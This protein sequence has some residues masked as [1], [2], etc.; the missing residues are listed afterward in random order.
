MR[1]N[2]NGTVID[3]TYQ[4]IFEFDLF[5]K[6]T[7]RLFFNE[8]QV[9]QY[10]EINGQKLFADFE[11]Y[12]VSNYEDIQELKIFT[13]SELQLLMETLEEGAAYLSKVLDEIENL[14]FSFYGEI[15]KKEWETFSQF[16]DGLQWIYLAIQSCIPIVEKQDLKIMNKDKLN[17]IKEKLDHSIRDLE[18]ALI[19]QEYTTVGDLIEYE[20]RP[21]LD[22]TYQIFIQAIG[23]GE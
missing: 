6:K 13:V 11:R 15:G 22:D 17:L 1:V 23:C 21:V 20:F 9:I 18:E 4:N 3:E 14:S 8:N 19:N 5:W 12:L 16:T 2:I 10:I 7:T